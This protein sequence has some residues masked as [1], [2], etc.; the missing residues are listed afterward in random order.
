MNTSLQRILLICSYLKVPGGYEKTVVTTANLF[1]EKGHPVHVLILDNSD[2]IFYPL[3]PAV[4]VIHRELH[5]G[6]TEKGNFLTRK[7]DFL[8][9]ISQLKQLI[10]QIRPQVVI[11]SEYQF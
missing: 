2:E 5:F 7:I 6:I 4:K 8:R 10:Q 11:A 9:H 3:H 1:A